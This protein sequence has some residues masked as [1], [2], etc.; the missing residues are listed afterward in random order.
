MD[1]VG[2]EAVVEGLNSFLG[3]LGKMDSGLSKLE[4]KGTLLQRTFSF[5]GETIS[6]FGRE[7]L[8]VAEYALGKVLGDSIEFVLEKIRDLVTSTIEAGQEFQT[9]SIRLDRLNFNELIASGASFNEAM[10]LSTQM[11]KEQLGWLQKLAAQTPYDNQDI[12]NVYT[13]ARSYGYAGDQAQGLTE[14]IINFAS[15][16]GLGNEEMERIIVNF[17]Q[18]TQ[19]G[20]V[21]GRELTDLARGAFVPVNKILEQMQKDTGLT[22][23]AFEDFRQTGEGV[24]A[25]MKAFS[26]VVATEFSGAAEK[27]ARTFEGASR[28]AADMVKS[29]LGLNI[30]KPLLDTIGGRIADFLGEFTKGRTIIKDF[31]GHL[32]EL[33]EPTRWDQLVSAASRIG[34]ALSEIVS[35]VFG[36]LPSTE[37]LADRVVSVVQGVADWIEG[38][39]T[40]IVNFFK[41]VGQAIQKK[42]IP[43]IEKIV[44]GFDTIADWV[45]N[46]KTLIGQFFGSL[47]DIIGQVIEDLTGRPIDTKGG[48]SGFLDV[49][50][51]IMEYVIKNKDK[52][53]KVIDAIVIGFIAFQ[54]V[55]TVVSFVVGILT[56]FIGTLIAVGTTV[57]GVLGILNFLWPVI[58]FIGTVITSVI[59]PAIGTFIAFLG[60]MITPILLVIATIALLVLAFNTDF[61]AIGET[62]AQLWF[63]VKFYFEK[64][65]TT[66]GTSL[67]QL[68]VIAKF[69]FNQIFANIKNGFRDGLISIEAF[70]VG[71]IASITKWAM[72][73]VAL[74]S[75][76]VANT[77]SQLA[78]W[79]ANVGGAIT[80]WA[81]DALQLIKKFSTE[82]LQDIKKFLSDSLSSFSNWATTVY[83]TLK[84]AVQSID[85]FGIGLSIINEII[86][87]FSSKS[88][89]AISP[90]PV[91]GTGGGGVGNPKGF[92]EGKGISGGSAPMSQSVPASSIV[93]SSVVINNEFN[94]EIHSSAA[95]EPIVQDFAMMQSMVNGG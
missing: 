24:E 43:F 53:A 2:V 3:D 28:N 71:A 10:A 90:P 48:L 79:V 82:G 75:T 34:T 27:L 69:Y 12:A 62:I 49:L 8:N 80:K 89:P 15:G 92:G 4:P 95:T 73:T 16:M 87:G 18:M 30:V 56:S 86:S 42:V 68:W 72:N 17:G 13:L 57:V 51:S 44:Q 76:W 29:I 32:V 47:G 67:S 58:A 88:L 1:K 9:L 7:V 38:H 52:I 39:K 84:S 19:Q 64:I 78:G 25:F 74:I 26:E 70:G 66:A 93:N 45:S 31:N 40:D 11:T 46:N 91:L 63:I 21:T 37:S 41:N 33:A 55:A 14:D 60:A 35:D 61:A 6:S 85:W 59:I 50:K 94:L 83:S 22:G 23:Q 54:V 36:L 20:K 5:L 81:A 77:K 65:M